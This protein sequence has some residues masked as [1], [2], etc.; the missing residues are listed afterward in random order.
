MNVIFGAGRKLRRW[1]AAPKPQDVY[2][3]HNGLEGGVGITG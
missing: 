2:G 1:R 3:P